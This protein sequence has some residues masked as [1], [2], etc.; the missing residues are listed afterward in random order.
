MQIEQLLNRT[1]HE[2]QVAEHR[3]HLP[4]GQIGEQHREHGRGTED[5]YTELEQQ[6]AGAVGGVGLPLRSD[7][8]IPDLSGLQT[9]AS[10]EE[11][12]PVTGADFLDCIQRLSER[13]GEQRS[14][15]VFQLFQ[16]FDPLAQLH[17]CVDHQR[18]EQED[19]QRQ[20]PMHPEQDRRR[21]D[22][23]KHGDQQTAKR[24]ANK[25]VDGLEI[26]DQVGSNG[27]ATQ[28]FVLAEGD[29]LESFDQAHSDAIDQILRQPSE[30]PGLQHVEGQ[31]RCAQ[32]QRHAKHQADIA[33]RRLP[34][35]RKKVVHYFECCVA[36]LQQH[37]INQQR[38]QQGD[39]HATQRRQ[40]R[41]KV[42]QHQGFTMVQREAADFGPAELIRHLCC[43][44]ASAPVMETMPQAV[45]IRWSPTP[46]DHRAQPAR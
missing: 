29:S 21:A 44:P 32:Q 24:L 35:W 26:G 1:N 14:A 23:G 37:L 20:L 6:T 38:Q 28:A 5:V 25:L 40:H 33:E 30:Q 19:Q 9:E 31:R 34:L 10:K 4:D 46:A 18:I 36:L 2:P 17:R 11:A 45:E 27:S 7:C 16:M 22:N 15:V 42:G 13:L 3:E 39:R 8:V 41:D 43:G 12:L